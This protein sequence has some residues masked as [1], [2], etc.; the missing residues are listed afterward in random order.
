MAS[1]LNWV[2]PKSASLLNWAA[3]NPAYPLNRAPLNTASPLNRAN[4][5][6]ATSDLSYNGTMADIGTDDQAAAPQWPT[7]RHRNSETGSP[8]IGRRVDGFDH[9]LAHLEPEQLAQA[10]QQFSPGADLQA[11]GTDINAELFAGI[12]Q[13]VTSGKGPPTFGVVNLDRAHFLADASF[14]DAQFSGHASFEG[15]Q[16]SKDATFSGAQFSGPARFGGAQFST[17]VGF[18]FARFSGDAVFSGA[19]FSGYAGFGAARF[20]GPARFDAAQF[21]RDADFGDTQFSKDATFSGAQF[22]GPF[23]FGGAQFS[24]HATFSDAKFE[25]ATKLGP[26]YAGRLELARA[27]F[28]H[29]VVI[30]AAADLVACDGATWEAGVTMRLRYAKVRLERATF[31][32]ASSIAGADEAF[33]GSSRGFLTP[34]PRE[35]EIS[36]R[37]AKERSIDRWVPVVSSLRGADVSNLSVIDVDLSQ[38]RFAGARLLDQLRVEGRCVFD[39]PPQWPRMG[40]AW[41]LVWRWTS[42]QSLA[43]ERIWRATTPKYSGWAAYRSWERA[44]V[45][46]ERLAGLYRQLRKA[47]EDAKNEPGAADF[48]YGEMEMRRRADSTP[49]VERAIIWM[50]WLISGYGLRALRSLAALIIVGVIVTAALLTWGLAGTTLSQHLTG[51]AT[52]A[53]HNPTRINAAIRTTTPQLPPASQRWTSQRT[54][55]A[56]EVT[57]ESMVFR[58]TSQPLTTAGTW[59]TIAAR[60]L[61]PIL[62]ALTLLAVRNRVK[63]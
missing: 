26:L 23:R 6:H 53:P 54:G 51:T 60:I 35:M 19:R 21:S 48:Y 43:E 57:I 2:S 59:T 33:R 63:R 16:F 13:A 14:A 3:P 58:S 52:T 20:S 36:S 11:P 62:L 47:Q 24:S 38:C 7:C 42:R 12:L 45:R 40:R 49:A 34:D 1:L 8:C 37:V 50:Y 46:P 56:V 41:P 9:C 32:V 22:S 4:H 61:G 30:E 5:W 55:T 31:S 39:H 44:E 18:N 17:G 15:A 27:V 28:V 10:L 29:M 25:G